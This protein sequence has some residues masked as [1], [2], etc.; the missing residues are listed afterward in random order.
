MELVEP[1]VQYKGS[2][3]EAVKE[4]QADDDYWVDLK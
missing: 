2:F 3:I 1:A 4:F